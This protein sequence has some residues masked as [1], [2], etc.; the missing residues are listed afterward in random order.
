MNRVSAAVRISIGLVCLAVGVLLTAR[1]LGLLPDPSQSIL[2]GRKQLCE[3]IA[4]QCSLAA[5]GKD[6]S[7]VEQTAAAIVHRNPDVLSIAVRRADGE[8]LLEAGKHRRRWKSMAGDASSPTQAKVPVY[9][10]DERWGTVE[11]RFRP[12]S[13]G[14]IRGFLLSQTFHLAVFVAMASFLVYL[15]FLRKA[16]QYLDPSSVIP[17]RVK[18]MLDALAEGVLVVDK[19]ERIVLA[20]RSFAETIGQSAASLQGKR[21]SSLGWQQVRCEEAPVEYPW[22][23]AISE[24]SA[25]MGSQLG[26]PTDSGGARTFT[27][28]SAPILAND[29]STRG[30][31]A[32]FDDVTAIEQKNLQLR[33]MLET[34]KRS[35]DEVDG[36]NRELMLLA[37]I[38][39]LTGC[40]NRRSF[41]R[42]FETQWSAAKRHDYHLGCVMI[43]I[44]HFKSINDK[45]GHGAGDR[46]LQQ[47]AE[48][49]KSSARKSDVVCRYG[50]EEFCILLPHS[51]I[52]KAATAAERYRLAIELTNCGGIRV[53]GSL[54]AASTDLGAQDLRELLNQAD[55]ALYAAKRAGRNRVIRWDEMSEESKAEKSRGATTGAETTKRDMTIPLH[56]VHALLSALSHRDVSTA[57]HSRRVAD[58]CVAA[59]DGIMGASDCFVLEVAA[60]LHDIGKLGVP[61]SILLKPG[62]LTEQEWKV[63]HAHGR[64]AVDI[65]ASAFASPELTEIIRTHHAWYGGSGPEGELPTGEHIPLAARILS[66]ADAFDAMTTDRPYRRAMTHSEAFAELRRCAGTQFDPALVERFVEVI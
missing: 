5:R 30:A 49:I 28:N 17:D 65:I 22:C 18:A 47:I 12:L 57:E 13:E 34:L 40:L 36:Q 1:A 2:D 46:V 10:G 15:L 25:A 35:R 16:L 55:M 58:F 54:G 19:S 6:T 9:K 38:D 44:D 48:A 62:P 14:G 39:P 33:E 50:G 64:M 7:A 21:A 8:I 42:T 29:G 31:L 66:L 56:A 45:Y 4:V 51:D 20:N 52:E 23:R 27:I 37:T 24:G 41:F 59:G 60:L 3:A 11:V 63:M 26:L 43:D 61:D 32:T 53:A